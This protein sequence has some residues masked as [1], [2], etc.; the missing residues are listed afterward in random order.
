MAPLPPLSSSPTLDYTILRQFVLSDH[1]RF[2]LGGSLTPTLLDVAAI[3]GLRP[4]GVTLSVAYNPDGASDFEAHLDLND[5]AYTKFLRKFA[6]HQ[7]EFVQAIPVP[8]K[9]FTANTVVN[10]P[11][12]KSTAETDRISAMGYRLRRFFKLVSFRPNHTGVMGFYYAVT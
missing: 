12:T 5:L 6:A 10:R 9:F 3:I 7:F 8:A 11:P 2:I 1:F 4:H